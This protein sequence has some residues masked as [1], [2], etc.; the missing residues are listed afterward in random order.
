[1]FLKKDTG[2]PGIAVDWIVIP[3]V[4]KPDMFNA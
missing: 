3:V 4:I 2:T 1:M